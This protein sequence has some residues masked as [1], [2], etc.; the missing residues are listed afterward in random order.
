MNQV[1]GRIVSSSDPPSKSE[2]SSSWPAQICMT[3]FSFCFKVWH[4]FHFFP[5][6]SSAATFRQ[7]TA[8]SK[9]FCQMTACSKTFCQMT[10]FSK[11]FCQMTACIKTLRQMTACSKTFCQATA[12]SN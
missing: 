12:C 6:L 10:A 1:N 8:C 4:S 3:G 9:T 5:C 11:T 7:V 2:V